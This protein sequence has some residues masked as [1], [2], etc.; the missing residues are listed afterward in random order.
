METDLIFQTLD[1]YSTDQDN[2]FVIYTF[3]VDLE[4]NSVTLQ[5]NNFCPFFFIEVPPKCDRG[6]VYT[7]KEVFG[8]RVK[9]I[10]FLQRKRYYGF[11][12]GKLHNFVKLTFYTVRNMRSLRAQI[13]ETEY[14]VF[15]TPQKFPLY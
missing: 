6:C 12:N 4:G 11:E 7:L 14:L 8:R 15:G 3:G 1:W 10:D 13:Q 5:I 9:K 2:A